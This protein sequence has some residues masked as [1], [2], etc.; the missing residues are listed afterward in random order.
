M[1]NK[2]QPILFKLFQSKDEGNWRVRV[3]YVMK[4]TWR[5]TQKKN[6]GIKQVFCL[7]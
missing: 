7:K 3:D 6:T 4:S 2:K 1:Y 5:P